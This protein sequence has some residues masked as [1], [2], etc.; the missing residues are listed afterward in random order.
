MSIF[1]ELVE[2]SNREVLRGITDEHRLDERIIGAVAG[3]RRLF[4]PVVR[5]MAVNRV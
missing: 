5:A 3:N 2:G 4:M 1:L